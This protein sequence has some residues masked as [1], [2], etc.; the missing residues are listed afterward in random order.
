MRFQSVNDIATDI[1][2]SSIDVMKVC[3][4]IRVLAEFLEKVRFENLPREVVEQAK[5]IILDSVGC[6]LGG[7]KTDLGRT[8]TETIKSLGGNS[9]S[10]IIGDKARTNCVFAAYTN[11]ILVDALDFEDTFHGLGH[12]SAT[13][14]PAALAMGERE[15]VDGK[16]LI[17]AVVGAYE[18]AVRLGFAIRPSSRKGKFGS[19]Q[20]WHTFG[21]AAAA[22]KILDLDVN[23]ILTTFGYSGASSPLPTF[24]GGDWHMKTRPLS[25]IKDNFGEVTAAGVLGAL[26]A[27]KNYVAPKSPDLDSWR[28]HESSEERHK[29]VV[30]GLGEDYK[31]LLTGLKPYTACRYVHSAL[32]GLQEILQENKIAANHVKNVI[33]HHHSN[34]VD[35]LAVYEPVNMVDAE[36][37]LPYTAAMVMMG[38]KPGLDWYSDKTMNDLATLENARKVHIRHSEESDKFL[39]EED[40]R[41]RRALA[42]VEVLTNDGKHYQKRAELTKG[43]PADPLTRAQLLEKFRDLA[44]SVGVQKN[45]TETIMKLTL[46]L[47]SLND[48]R[49][50]GRL[51]C[52]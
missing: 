23:R 16:R 28:E 20:Y 35:G 6:A 34:V 43:D 46:D 3:D 33:I 47:E 38:K 49:E 48:V 19:F 25:W 51:L 13:I 39:N 27:Q 40:Y 21:S 31:I 2:C 44:T 14:I 7:S 24:V 18:V 11:A 26:L 50:L 1:D 30:D 36:F 15:G 29:I 17:T 37:S 4:P 8:I 10:T 45:K 42:I 5:C 12:P 52:S 9:E 22:S 41:K 32:G